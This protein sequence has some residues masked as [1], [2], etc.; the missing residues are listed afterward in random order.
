MT[1]NI[2][3]ERTVVQS[4]SGCCRWDSPTALISY[5]ELAR[6]KCERARERSERYA[7]VT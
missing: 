6:T 4:S 2:I 3:T 1:E 5:H 7:K